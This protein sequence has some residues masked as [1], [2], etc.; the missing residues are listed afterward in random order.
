ITVRRASGSVRVISSLFQSRL[1]FKLGGQGTAGTLYSACL[2][3][4]KIEAV[5]VEVFHRELMQSP[6]LLFERLNDL[7]TQR[8]QLVVGGIDVGRKYPVYR[9][10][11]GLAFAAEE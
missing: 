8:A 9:R 4:E 1:T 11:E 7:R 2:I 6:G 10:L 3:A 5:A